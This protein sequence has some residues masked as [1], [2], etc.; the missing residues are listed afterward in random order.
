MYYYHLFSFIVTISFI[1]ITLVGLLQSCTSIGVHD[2]SLHH[3]GGATC[4]TLPVKYGLVWCMC[5]CRV[6]DHHN[7]LCG[8]PLLKKTCAR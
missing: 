5:F 2:L 3:L 7:L 6:K 4:L 1:V 8:A